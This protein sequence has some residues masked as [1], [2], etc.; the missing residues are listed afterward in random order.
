M[1]EDK[2]GSLPR[3]T[4]CRDARIEE[5]LHMYGYL[6]LEDG[7][8]FAG[9][10][11]GAPGEQVGEVVFN[12]GMT[13]YQE[14]LTDPS[15]CG[16]IV[17]MTYPLIGN[18]GIN[19]QDFESGRSWVRGFIVKE[20]CPEP[21]HWEATQS[22]SDYLA[23]QN[24]IGLAGIDTRALTRH[25]RGGGTLR[26]VI[27]ARQTALSEVETAAL[28]AKAR[29]FVMTSHVHEVTTKAIYHRPG[30]GH[31]VVVM[32]FGLKENILRS[33]QQL[34]CAVT[35]VPATTSAEVI[36]ALK[37]DGIML[38]NGPG[39]PTDVPEAIETVKALIDHGGVPVF[40]ICLG[41]QIISLALGAKTYKLK[42]GH[43]GA[44]HPVKDFLTGRVYIT[45]QNH[46]YAVDDS[47]LDKRFVQVTHRNLNDGTVEGIA[48]LHA[49][50]F[51]VQYHPEACPGP[52]ESFYLFERFYGFMKNKKGAALQPA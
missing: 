31:H 2:Q 36:L 25:L 18:Y 16:Q 50:V 7:H 14:V 51:S 1:G 5:D 20:Y 30:K 13:G 48:M 3:L 34:G 12:T 22:L 15:Y 38:T 45:S 49:P 9:T 28:V 35:V 19:P 43:R 29:A 10:A 44:N 26:G 4:G 42:F 46:G 6:V 23:S 39:D 33:L 11:F 47:T 37:P 21:S 24:V 52:E 32:D 17:T 40:G 8:V 41:H 27:V